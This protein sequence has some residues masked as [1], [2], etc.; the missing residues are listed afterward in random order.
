MKSN[1]TQ[2]LQGRGDHGGRPTPQG[3]PPAN[4]YVMIQR[5]PKPRAS[6][7]VMAITPFRAAAGVELP[8]I[9]LRRFD[10]VTK[11]NEFVIENRRTH[12]Q[13]EVTELRQRIADGERKLAELD[14]ERSGIMRVLTG[15]GDLDDFMRI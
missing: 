3:Y 10:E 8:G 15:R 1:L 7:D 5:R 9:A 11:F 13:R 12:L 2:R 6:V 4:A 14:T